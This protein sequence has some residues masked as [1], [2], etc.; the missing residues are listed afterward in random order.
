MNS[1]EK[2]QKHIEKYFEKIMKDHLPA[3]KR[4]C[5]AYEA[6]SDL[7]QELLQEILLNIWRSLPTY[8]QEASLTTWMYRVALNVAIRHS[9]N[10]SRDPIN[11]IKPEYEQLHNLPAEKEDTEE[12]IEKKIALK[13]LRKS[14][15]SLPSL[16]RQ[17]MILYLEEIS[18]SEIAD[19]TGLSRDNIS[20]KVHR[21]KQLLIKKMRRSL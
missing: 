16:D 11:Q 20:T 4:L 17:I 1:N 7:R 18:Q 12:R 3:L 8:R 13:Q 14:I 21:I 5:I 10:S 15:R 9:T 6:S 19:I 2:P